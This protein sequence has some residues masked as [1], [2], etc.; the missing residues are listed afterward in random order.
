MKHKEYIINHPSQLNSLSVMPIMRT[1]ALGSLRLGGN[2]TTHPKKAL[3]EAELNKYYYACGCDTGAVGLIIGLFCGGAFAIFKYYQQDWKLGSAIS[4][5]FITTILL[6][7]LGKLFGLMKARQELQ[8]TIR[9][10]QQKWIP[11]Q[12]PKHDQLSCG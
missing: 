9:V 7:G 8:K 6:T 3:W 4:A 11:E 12:P 10:I 5:I 1:K 2:I